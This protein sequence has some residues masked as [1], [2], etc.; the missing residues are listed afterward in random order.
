M[1]SF[2]DEL[3]VFVLNNLSATLLTFSYLF[4]ILGAIFGTL[5][6]ALG[7]FQ[8]FL[9]NLIGPWVKITKPDDA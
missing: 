6:I 8:S 5:R 2:I 4:G 7:T 3:F 9:G 1:A